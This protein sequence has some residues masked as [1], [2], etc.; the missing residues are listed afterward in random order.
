M[1]RLGWAFK[2]VQGHSPLVLEEEEAQLLDLINHFA[3]HGIIPTFGS[4]ADSGNSHR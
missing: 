1:Q 3:Q 2:R 4:E